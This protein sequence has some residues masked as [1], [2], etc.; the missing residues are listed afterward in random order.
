ML[1]LDLKRIITDIEDLVYMTNGNKSKDDWNEVEL[2]AF[3]T[4]PVRLAG[5]LKISMM[6]KNVEIRHLLSGIGFLIRRRESDERI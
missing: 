3:L 5:C 6:Q 4:R 2:M 1:S